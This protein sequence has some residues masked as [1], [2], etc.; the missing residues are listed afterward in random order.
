MCTL[1][2]PSMI[3]ITMCFA[4]YIPNE[5]ALVEVAT[6]PFGYCV[7]AGEV[8]KRYTSDKNQATPARYH[9]SDHNF[10]LYISLLYG[11]V[12]GNIF[13]HSGSV[14]ELIILSHDCIIG[15]GGGPPLLCQRRSN[16][17]YTSY[18]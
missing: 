5:C 11:S 8:F 15:L 9:I 2:L 7:H 16:D 13:R 1:I 12:V 3:L 10:N 17:T 14:F 4:T 6:N 18:Y